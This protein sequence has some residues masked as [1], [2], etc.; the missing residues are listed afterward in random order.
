[1]PHYNLVLTVFKGTSVAR[2]PFVHTG[3]TTSRRPTRSSGWLMPLI[4]SVFKTAV[5]SS[6]VFYS[7]KYGIPDIYPP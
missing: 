6:K 3:R 7:K 5:T 2:R 4:R 1:M